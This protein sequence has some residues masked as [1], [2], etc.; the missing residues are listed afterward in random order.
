MFDRW[1]S[2]RLV[3]FHVLGLSL[4]MRASVPP[5]RYE[6]SSSR[7]QRSRAWPGVL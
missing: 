3:T 6:K 7:S 2:S 4:H 5:A 1:S